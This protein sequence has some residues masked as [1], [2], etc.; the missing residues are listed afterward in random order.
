METVLYIST[1]YHG[2][3]ISIDIVSWQIVTGQVFG[4]RA[5]LAKNRLNGEN[6][7]TTSGNKK[8]SPPRPKY[9]WR[10]LELN[11]AYGIELK[12][13]LAILASADSVKLQLLNVT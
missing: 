10:A 2:R 4:I 1:S 11:D 5:G 13:L 12:L 3:K 7:R 8:R 9:S 6:G